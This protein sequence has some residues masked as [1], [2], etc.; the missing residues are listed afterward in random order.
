VKYEAIKDYLAQFF[1]GQRP[2]GNI[3][4]LHKIQGDA[5]S[6]KATLNTTGWAKLSDRLSESFING[7]DEILARMR[8]GN[9]DREKLLVQAAVVLSRLELINTI[10]IMLDDGK[11]AAEELKK[12]V[13]APRT[14]GELAEVT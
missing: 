7:L 2:E 14:I 3:S 4:N 1:T 9:Y 5:A 11:V 12:Q 8:D 13:Q 6:L 10:N